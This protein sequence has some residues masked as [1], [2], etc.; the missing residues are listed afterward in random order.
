M[1]Y[2]GL[3]IAKP[4][5]FVGVSKSFTVWGKAFYRVDNV[6]LSGAPYTDAAIYCNPLSASRGLSATFPGFYGVQITDFTYNNENMLTFT[7]PSASKIGYVDV[8][9]Q[10]E[11]GY[12][13]LTKFTIK[14]KYNPYKT[15]TPEY[16]AHVPYV[17]PWVDGIN[18]LLS[19]YNF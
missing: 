5:I 13:A 14:S 10:N 11:V 3:K 19:G 15:T 9:L 1:R 18:V 6:F 4:E 16:S 12:G 17:P 7:M 8:I 2:V